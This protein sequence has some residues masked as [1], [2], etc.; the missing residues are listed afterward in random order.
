MMSF[1]WKPPTALTIKSILVFV[2]VIIS[3]AGYTYIRGAK[4]IPNFLLQTINPNKS[5]VV[6]YSGTT[7][8]LYKNIGEELADKSIRYGIVV[9][10][11]TSS[12]GTENHKQIVASTQ[13]TMGLI[14]EDEVRDDDFTLKKV[15]YIIPVYIERFHVLYN[16]EKFKEITGSDGKFSIQQELDEKSEN[17]LKESVVHAANA[18][19]STRGYAEVVLREAGWKGQFS[20]RIIR[21]F[22]DRVAALEKGE[23]DILIL[24]GGAPLPA[25]K[26]K[27]ASDQNRK[28]R[29]AS[30]EPTYI[31]HLRSKYEYN[32][33]IVDFDGLYIKGGKRI[34]TFGDYAYLAAS[35]DVSNEIIECTLSIFNSI[36]NMNSFRPLKELPFYETYKSS[37]A[38]KK[39]IIF[40]ELLIFIVTTFI[41]SI[42]IFA[43]VIWI[44]SSI[45]KAKYIEE[46]I[47]I[48]KLI[49]TDLE[50]KGL[51]YGYIKAL[52][53]IEEL[54]HSLMKEYDSGYI[55][56]K[57]VSILLKYIEMFRNNIQKEFTFKIAS[58]LITGNKKEEINFSTLLEKACLRL[59][60]YEFLQMLKS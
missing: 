48:E 32:F 25:L 19:G 53:A 24:F 15:K 26:S 12:G 20:D 31:R 29:L 5:K 6:F 9:E 33:R 58:L 40:K 23:I 8:G 17:F 51:E 10:H 39:F 21:T 2:A 34:M 28:I 38:N 27:L 42:A 45:K 35:P 60:Q 11:R 13:P 16:I 50:K 22:A 3:A 41:S 56:D 36:K 49:S 52:S 7:G 4:S 43:S 1:D 37:I 55:K 18:P 14:Q 30:I 44:L 54:Q 59:P 57:D 46:L 47:K